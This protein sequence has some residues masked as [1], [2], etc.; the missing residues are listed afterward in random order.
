MFQAKEVTE[1]LG[2]LILSVC[3]IRVVREWMGFSLF[4][5][6]NKFKLTYLNTFVLQQTHYCSGIGG[7]TVRTYLALLKLP[8]KL[9]LFTKSPISTNFSS[10][11]TTLM[12][13]KVLY[14]CT[15]YCSGA[16]NL[17]LV[18]LS[19]QLMFA[20]SEK[21]LYKLDWLRPSCKGMYVF[22]AG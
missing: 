3:S 8:I 11:A 13:V 21:K 16:F 12:S 18:H 1:I 15:T 9:T 5:R 19:M 2:Y 10:T 20:D 14:S 7:S 4:N 22:C 6:V 17:N